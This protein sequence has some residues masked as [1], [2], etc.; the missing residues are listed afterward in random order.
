[1]SKK[2]NE[3]D[4]AE[5]VVVSPEVKVTEIA[6]DYK[7]FEKKSTAMVTIL[8]EEDYSKANDFLI[9][10][11]GRINRVKALKE[12]YIKPLKENIKKLE[13]L[14]TEPQKNYEQIEATMKRAMGDYRL[15]IEEEARKKE[16]EIKK[17]QEEEAR[18][19]AEKAKEA[20][21]EGKP[22]P[23]PVPKPIVATQVARPE[24]TVGNDAGK[25]TA[26][27]VVKFEITDADAIPKK[28]KDLV[29]A[30]AVKKG[31]LKTILTPIVKVEGMTCDIKGIRVYEDFDI[32]VTA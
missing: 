28:Y 11:K 18:I 10:V 9:E 7:K 4:S 5:V 6:A 29:Y 15:M 32:S 26:K 14:F 2:K 13:S 23:V 12:E 16:A 25:S 3:N 19:A 21:A 27:K 1:M 17:Q 22:V 24:A 8:G 20:A 31:I 30:E